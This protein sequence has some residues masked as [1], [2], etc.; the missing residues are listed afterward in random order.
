[1][2]CTTNQIYQYVCVIEIGTDIQPIY[3][4]VAV[5][6]EKPLSDPENEEHY[7]I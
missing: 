2:A 1:M 5:P 3:F 4:P 6:A 7:Y